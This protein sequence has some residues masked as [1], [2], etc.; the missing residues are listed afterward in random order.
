MW[1]GDIVHAG[2]QYQKRV[3][4]SG[5]GLDQPY[6]TV[7]SRGVKVGGETTHADTLPNQKSHSVTL[8]YGEFVKN[9]NPV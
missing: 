4:C 3:G 7:A 2:K 8:R 1:F 9:S 5:R 6:N